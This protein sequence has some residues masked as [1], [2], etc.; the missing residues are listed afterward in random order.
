MITESR[1]ASSHYGF[2]R[3][4]LPMGESY[5][6]GSNAELARFAPPLHGLS[7]PRE[8]GIVNELSF[9]VFSLC[10]REDCDPRDLSAEVLAREA[11]LARGFIE[12]FRQHGRGV[13]PQVGEE[14]FREAIALAERT[15]LFFRHAATPGRSFV[16][17]PSFSGC[18]W[19]SKCNGDVLWKGTIYELKAGQRS[20]R[21]A[22]LR[23]VLVYCALGFASKEHE[24]DRVCF[25]NPRQGVY[26]SESLADLCE[27]VSGRSPAEVLNDIVEYVSGTVGIY[28][29]G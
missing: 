17:A 26:F 23:Q 5:I 24:I 3:E 2:W 28:E 16:V 11:E 8:R 10:E 19:L 14:G 1:F 25:V 7:S 20:F 6:R 12:N 22:D 27:A 4:L 9:R 21:L 13:L 15:Q 18:G 29:G